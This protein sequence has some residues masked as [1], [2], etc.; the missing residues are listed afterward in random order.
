MPL[1]Y[2]IWV[3]KSIRFKQEN[4]KN[5]GFFVRPDEVLLLIN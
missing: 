4:Q 2:M 5:V 1:S 3:K